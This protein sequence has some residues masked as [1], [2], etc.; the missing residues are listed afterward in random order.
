MTGPAL[1]LAISAGQESQLFFH[2]LGAI[3]LFGATGA[4][5]WLAIAGRNRAEQHSLARASF[6]IMLLLA[7]PAWV[8]M[9]VFGTWAE[10]GADYPKDPSWLEIG[11]G[12]ASV[13][14]LILLAITAFAYRWMRKPAGDWSATAVA[15]LSAL[16]VVLLAV[17]WWVMSAKVP[18]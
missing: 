17:A 9:L 7:L 1:L 12:I 11:S 6:K 3:A 14:V 8:L 10:S 15:I 16:Y 2:V 4:V 13:G 5:A 18:S